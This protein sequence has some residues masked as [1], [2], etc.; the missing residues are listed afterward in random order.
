MGGSNT[1]RT[2]RHRHGHWLLWPRPH[3]GRGANRTAT[4]HRSRLREGCNIDGHM[5]PVRGGANGRRCLTIGDSTSGRLGIGGSADGR[6]TQ[7]IR[8]GA[9]G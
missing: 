5:R 6:R 3:E 9:D 2:Y 1:L 4:R 8:R 7:A